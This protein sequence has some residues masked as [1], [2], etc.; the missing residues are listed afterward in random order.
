MTAEHLYTTE[1]VKHHDRLD[2]ISDISN[3]E[4]GYAAKRVIRNIKPNETL[5]DVK[6][7]IMRKIMALKFDQNDFIRYKL[8]GTK[9]LL[10]EATK[11]LEFNCGLTLGQAKDINSKDMKGKNMLGTW[12][13]EY[14]DEII[15]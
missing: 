13:C 9:G 12:L 8:L 3:A 7:K 5:N 11:D 10:F 2:L 1:F 15:G 4:D 6:M 14:R